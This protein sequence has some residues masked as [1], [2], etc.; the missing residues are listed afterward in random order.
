MCMRKSTLVEMCNCAELRGPSGAI[1]SRPFRSTFLFTLNG[2][3][4]LANFFARFC[5]MGLPRNFYSFSLGN[6]AAVPIHRVAK[7]WFKG[8]LVNRFRPKPQYII[9]PKHHGV[10]S[11][12][13]AFATHPALILI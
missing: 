10:V 6:R 12:L 11:G 9:T 5:C 3:Q 13:Y 7:Q 1:F 2:F 4:H 8:D